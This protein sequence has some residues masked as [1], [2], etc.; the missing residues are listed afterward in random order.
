MNVSLL[1]TFMSISMFGYK[2]KI[3]MKPFI[4]CMSFHLSSYIVWVYMD[5]SNWYNQLNKFKPR[6]ITGV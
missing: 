2:V 4:I 3:Q 6:L 1:S 5:L